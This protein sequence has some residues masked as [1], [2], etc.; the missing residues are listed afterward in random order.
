[1][2]AHYLSVVHAQTVEYVFRGARADCCVCL[3]C[4]TCRLL[5]MSFVVHVLT[6]VNVFRG[7]RA[8]C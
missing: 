4:C 7:A 6:V 2:H 8:D 5:S 3:S 1:M